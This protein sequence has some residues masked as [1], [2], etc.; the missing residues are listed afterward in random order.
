MSNVYWELK[1]GFVDI[2]HRSNNTISSLTTNIK[3][4]PSYRTHPTVQP[5]GG[6]HRIA[7]STTKIYRIENKNY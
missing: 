1:L 3:T 4:P 5:Q 6:V 7:I 2:K